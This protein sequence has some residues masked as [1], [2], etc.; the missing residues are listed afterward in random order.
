M[1]TTLCIIASTLVVVQVFSLSLFYSK[2]SAPYPDF[3]K[4]NIFATVYESTSHLASIIVTRSAK[5]TKELLSK[6]VR[7]DRKNNEKINILIMP[8][9]EPGYG[10]AEYIDPIYGEIIEREVVVTLAHALEQELE[11]NIHYNVTVARTNADWHESIKNYFV[12][13]WEYIDE[14]RIAHTVYYQAM[15]AVGN[16][17]N[18]SEHQKVFH[19]DAPENVARRL[20]GINS[21]ANENNIDIAIHL[22]I[23]DYPRKNTDIP[24]KHV[25]F[26]IYVPASQYNNSKTAKEIAHNIYGELVRHNT[27][28]TLT[29]E[30]AG[31]VD[32]AELIAVGANNTSDSASILIE[33]GYIY[34]SALN[35]PQ[36]QNFLIQDWAKSTAQ[37]I[38]S[39]FKQK[40][41]KMYS[42]SV[43]PYTFTEPINQ[44]NDELYPV[45]MYALQTILLNAGFFNYPDDNGQNKQ[46]YRSLQFD[47]CTTDAIRS[48]QKELGFSNE[49]LTS[50]L[51]VKTIQEINSLIY[52]K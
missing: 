3:A 17:P 41:N 51:D 28:S 20:Y 7:A 16:S 27:I 15:Q 23:N 43:L 33:Y 35:N 34:E 45:G 44:N 2:F 13:S 25:G 30:S 11:K 42:S 12:Q 31:I 40:N 48:L 29:G 10:G 52:N 21:W 1:K 50:E 26:A 39:Y 22:H 24:G 6:Y 46:C 14:W 8:G 47:S 38:N 32:D 49:D 9:H 36:T 18:I 37:G 19:K 5:S 4:N